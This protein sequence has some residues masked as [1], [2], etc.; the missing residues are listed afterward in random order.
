MY[1]DY[2]TDTNPG[3]DCADMWIWREN[4]HMNNLIFNSLAAELAGKAIDGNSVALV[5]ENWLVR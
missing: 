2:S 4:A 5:A 3:T 1:L